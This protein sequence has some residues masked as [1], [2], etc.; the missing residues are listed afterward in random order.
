MGPNKDV[1]LVEL[2]KQCGLYSSKCPHCGRKI[3]GIEALR[4]LFDLILEEVSKAGV[5]KI[6]GFG[7]F[8]LAKWKAPKT[9]ITEGLSHI[10]RIGFKPSKTAKTKVLESLK[11]E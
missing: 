11:E 2:A 1:G 4:A 10:Y 9:K 6:M 7:S 5:V 8:R 3:K